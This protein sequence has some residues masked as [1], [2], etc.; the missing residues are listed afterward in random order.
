MAQ[1]SIK[2]KLASLDDMQLYTLINTVALASGL[3]KQKA[4]SLTSDIP[5]LR[6]MLSSLTDEQINTLISSI[7][8][9]NVSISEIVDRL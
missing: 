4:N 3:D 1:N 8:R 6:R 5:R 7:G 9:G 2:A